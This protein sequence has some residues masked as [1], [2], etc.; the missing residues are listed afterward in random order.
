MLRRKNASTRYRSFALVKPHQVLDAY[1]TLASATDWKTVCKASTPMPWARKTRRAYKSL[2]ASCDDVTH[3]VRMQ[4]GRQIIVT[5]R[6]LR[7]VT[8]TMSER[9][10]GKTG[11]LLRFLSTN[12]IS[13][14]FLRFN[15]RLFVLAHSSIESVS[16]DRELSLMAG[17]MRYVRRQTCKESSR[18]SRPWDRQY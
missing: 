18:E 10:G 9:G 12:T 16:A 4:I 14:V 11:R 6:I 2:R 17:T 13:W 8:R 1:I 15:T 5:P 3:V 7:D